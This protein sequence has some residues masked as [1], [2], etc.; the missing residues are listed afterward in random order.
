MDG[1]AKAS[2]EC[3]GMNFDSS[4]TGMDSER[5]FTQNAGYYFNGH[6]DEITVIEGS[7]RWKADFTPPDKPAL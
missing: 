1:T 3:T 6:M 5:V 7:P 2:T 4:K